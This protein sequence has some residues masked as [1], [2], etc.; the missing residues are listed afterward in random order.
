MSNQQKSK[1]EL[2]EELKL[3]R[4][5]YNNLKKTVDDDLIEK[6]RTEQ[7]LLISVERYNLA[8]NASNDGLFDWNLETNEIYY[9]P[10]WKN[11]L[12]YNDHEL[13][14]DFSVWEKT[15]L[16][17]DVEKS[18][19][20][21]QKLISGEIERFVLEFKMKHKNGQWIDILS[22]AKAIFND[23]GKAIRIVGTH[24][25]ISARKEAEIKLRD[26]KDQFRTIIN[27]LVDPIFVKDNE[28][29]LTIVNK[30][31]CKIFGLEEKNVIG[32]TLAENVPE[33]ER[34]QFLAVDRKVLDTGIPDLREE[35]LTVN[36]KTKKIITSKKRFVDK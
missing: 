20:L 30:A 9:S 25:D 35:T 18:W 33:K 31:F 32:Y 23:K 17:S 7:E 36:N 34:E 19:K 11:M 16:S 10:A 24:T 5:Q 6:R 12:G 29:R 8:M 2:I 26:E 1:G 28:H 15:T 13:L 4:E 27:M 14:N 3:L 22:Q 21:Q